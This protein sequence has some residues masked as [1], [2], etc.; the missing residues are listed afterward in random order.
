[1]T[2]RRQARLTGL[3]RNAVY[4]SSAQRSEVNDVLLPL[5]QA[6]LHPP[7]AD[8]S[9]VERA[10]LTAPFRAIPGRKLT[11][12]TAPAGYGK[13]SLMTQAWRLLDGAPSQRA[14]LTLDASDNDCAQLIRALVGA[15]GTARPGFG[16]AVSV[17][18]QGG[19]S[20]SAETIVRVLANALAAIETP[21]RF[22]LEDAHE[23]ADPRAL[24]VIRQLIAGTPPQVQFAISSRRALDLGTGRLRAT[25]QLEEIDW[26]ALRFT[27]PEV[28][29]FFRRA[30]DLELSADL[31]TR[32]LA[33]TEGWAAALKLTTLSIRDAG[34]L[35]VLLERLDGDERGI[36]AYLAEDVLAH[37]APALRDFLLAIAPLDRVCASLCDAIT[38][39][40]NAAETLE[41][42]VD[43]NLFVFATEGAHR[44][45]RFHPLFSA[46]L[47]RQVARRDPGALDRLYARASA[48]FEAE[49]AW[50]AAVDYALR[51]GAVGRA[52]EILDQHAF[53]IWRAGHQSRLD[54]WARQIP[55]DIRR[56]HPQL[57]LVQAWSLTLAG[58]VA[59]A[60]RILEEVSAQ[61][62]AQ[63][64]AGSAR[65][66]D[67][68]FLR[69]M[70]A[71][72][73]ED[74]AR[75]ES[76]SAHWLAGGYSTDPFLVGAVKSV[77]AGARGLM[78]ELAYARQE[79]AGIAD[80]LAE[81]GTSYAP[82]WLYAILG[83]IQLGAGDLVAAAAALEQAIAFAIRVGGED[84]PLAAMPAMILARVR[85]EAGDLD[86]ARAIA[87]RHA[88]VAD[89]M[90]FADYQISAFLV[91]ARLHCAAG[92]IGA[93]LASLDHHDACSIREPHRAARV[94]AELV[95]ERIRL[96]ARS[97]RTGE[98]AALA[99]RADLAA[100][101]DAY[102][103]TR[104]SG[105]LGAVRAEARIRAA[106]A[107]GEPQ[108]ALALSRQWIRFTLERD[109]PRPELGFRLLAARA[110]SALGEDAAARRELREA[111]RRGAKTGASQ[112]FLDEAEA[113]GPALRHAALALCT[114]APDARPFLDRVLR[115]LTAP[116]PAPAPRIDVSGPAATRLSPRELEVLQLVA[117]GLSN[118]EV[119]AGLGL[120]ENTVKW[121]LRQLF[122]KLAVQR[123]SQAILRARERG[124]IG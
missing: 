8:L 64:D 120:T 48:W 89:R 114:T 32:V 68:L 11:L 43:A 105:A 84:T 123:R 117:Q 96:L 113:L 93:A 45:Y 111:L 79:A 56:H 35:A 92:D 17:L 44:W 90:N 54:G 40:R 27:D 112:L 115:A 14:W 30:L 103:P 13:T 6:K 3:V 88:H 75:T 18:L 76:L 25:G 55:I 81:S 22:F 9:L 50:D 26:S 119:G 62:D 61:I 101:I 31:T 102:A 38:G 77:L 83:A 91:P 106:L 98:L 53:D 86:A 7:I 19:V 10:R 39:L 49:R 108:L 28:R 15:A 82:I 41:H 21:F 121:N 110:L 99:A 104:P 36:A 80:L 67:V 118:R 70:I 24:A 57:R 66:G 23:L 87:G 95:N 97:K 60:I 34:T 78:Y 63:G 69:L 52:A 4:D 124:L 109:A 65:V 74:N 85:Y 2:T 100:P 46:F 73:T 12:V 1:M 5:L 47:R 51:A 72:Y 16:D 122:Q 37:L 42:I 107:L 29:A 116:L 59:A 20:L 71:F 94:G 58:K 33:K